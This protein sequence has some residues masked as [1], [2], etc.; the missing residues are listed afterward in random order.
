MTGRSTRASW[1]TSRSETGVPGD[2][3]ASCGRGTA[4][5][6]TAPV[7]AVRRA[8]SPSAESGPGVGPDRA[9]R[10]DDRDVERDDDDRPHGVVGQPQKFSSADRMAS[11]MPATSAHR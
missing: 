10:P 9:E 8:S 11:T 1:S 6:A 2:R 4:G 5:T 3:C 7:P